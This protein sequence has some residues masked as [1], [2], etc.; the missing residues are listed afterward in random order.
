MRLQ[1][2]AEGS[3]VRAAKRGDALCAGWVPARAQGG[4]WAQEAG[5]A[6]PSAWPQWASSPG[7]D[8]VNVW[9]PRGGAGLAVDGVPRR[10]AG[11]AAGDAGLALSCSRAPRERSGG[12]RWAR[13][14]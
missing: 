10:R 5:S 4:S 8:Q 2:P 6:P 1:G 11:E 13:G 14:C 3:G 12:A 7:G 9:G